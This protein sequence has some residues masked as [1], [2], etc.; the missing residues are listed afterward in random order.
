MPKGP[1]S[2]FTTTSSLT[3]SPLEPKENGEGAVTRFGNFEVLTN[4]DGGL[5]L[6]GGGGFG[7]T[8][9]AR[10]VYLDQIVALKVIN[11]R[12]LHDA[13]IKE[14][15]LREAQVVHQL[16][17]P[18]IAH[19]IDFGEVKHSL[20]YAMEFCG[21][22]NLENMVS[23]VGPLSLPVALRC[24][25]QLTEALGCAH[26]RGFIHRDVK[27]ANV[28]LMAADDEN[29]QIKL[30]DF[31]LVKHLQGGGSE[32][33]AALTATGQ[34][35]FTIQFASPEQL[36]EE[37]LDPRS[38]LFALGMTIWFLLKGS[39]P[40][41]GSMASI[42][43]RRL[44][45]KSYEAQLPPDLPAAYRV[46]LARLLEKD[47]THRFQDTSEVLAALDAAEAAPD[48]VPGE[49]ET[50]AGG[51]T[52]VLPRDLEAGSAPAGPRSILEL[53]TVLENLGPMPL[54]TL[55]RATSNRDD[56]QVAITMVGDTLRED[57][58]QRA[59]IE[60]NVALLRTQPHETMAQIYGLEE[61]QEGLALIQE[62]HRGVSLQNVLKSARSLHYPDALRVLLPIARGTDWTTRQ[63]LPGVVLA[64]DEI[65]LQPLDAE[66]A[67]PDPAKLLDMP[68]K[69]WPPFRVRLLPYVIREDT[70]EDIGR[71]LN[72]EI[73]A[74][75]AVAFACLLYH[76]VAGHTPRAAAR[77]SKSAYVTI[78]RFTEDSNRLLA[79]CIAG[80]QDFGGCEGMLRALNANEGVSFSSGQS[81]PDTGASGAGLL[82]VAKSGVVEVRRNP[83]AGGGIK[84]GVLPI[85]RSPRDLAREAEEIRAKKEAEEALLRK[86]QAD[87]ERALQEAEEA[88][89]RKQQADEERAKKEAEEARL[90]KQQ[91]EE[92]RTRKEAA[93]KLLKQ[94]QAEEARLRQE[95]AEKLLK[96]R[97]A[98]EAQAKKL[99][100]EERARKEAA[101]QLLKQRQAEEAQAK[102]LAEEERA[103]KEAEAKQLKK[104]QAEEE[105]ARKE[106][107][108]RQL[109]QKQA[110]EARA[111]KQADEE[112]AKKEAEEARLRKQQAEEERT[113]KEAAEKLLKQRQAEEARLRQEAAEK[114]LK[115]KQA[116]EAQA[117][118]LAEEERARKEAAEKLLKQ[119]QAEEARA[120]KQAEE[121]RARKEAE[122]ARLRK[123]QAEEE[124][125]R[126][127]AAE[128]LLKQQQAEEARAK[129]LAAQTLK[130]AA[131]V[132]TSKPGPGI[133][134]DEGGE[135]ETSSGL[136]PSVSAAAIAASVALVGVVAFVVLHKPAPPKQ[137]VASPTPVA[138]DTPKPTPTAAP[139]AVPLP[140]QFVFKQGIV[141]TRAAITLNGQAVNPIVDGMKVVVPLDGAKA[142][143]SLEV[144]APGYESQSFPITGSASVDGRVELHRQQ[145]AITFQFVDG[146]SDYAAAVFN[147]IKALPGEEAFV[148]MDPQDTSLALAAGT[149]GF[150][151]TGIYRVTLIARPSEPQIQGRVLEPRLSV[152]TQRNVLTIPPSFAGRYPFEFVFKEDVLTPQ[153]LHKID[154]IKVRRTIVIDPGL[155][156]GYADD[157]YEKA[158]P[159]TGTKITDLT[160]NNQ[161]VLHGFIRF[162]KRTDTNVS[163]DEQFELSYVD[164]H[165]DV[166]SGGWEVQP[167]AAEMARLVQKQKNL[168]GYKP[169]LNPPPSQVVRKE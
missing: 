96:Q 85:G 108:A 112:R 8:Y 157:F 2:N 13:S 168:Q 25:R 67:G 31:G 90:R 35:F 121:E 123:Q 20:Y 161:G 73:V 69:S 9:K 99:A 139:T 76:L 93:E 140:G 155:Q 81:K 109:K 124:R 54:G 97:Q 122:E 78:G 156:T 110:E 45:G 116:E 98:E 101:E 114:L 129:K 163:C 128:K 89:L 127:A 74:D 135:R 169:H 1:V 65:Y 80:E 71:T 153:K 130:Q 150:L 159:A 15:F 148:H 132:E 138:V 4:P 61:Y 131:V 38:D 18:N 32:A 125:A 158:A 26:S 49:G 24:A 119:R 152:T 30:V 37:E 41:A 3:G 17:H 134:T 147:P 126:Q 82:A 7:K 62:W 92:E 63:G 83:Q 53:Y 105:R 33:T 5:H 58:L 117:K 70:I 16:R 19:V 107:E 141:P 160:L 111:K 151:P 118:K 149:K 55:Y 27:P 137:E 21:G 77:L 113:R 162:T 40:E 84:G 29:P 133:A 95:A 165:F 66:A 103:R 22:G 104:Q 102:K 11:D 136:P 39:A 88:L 57:P 166:V 50:G 60:K 47:R 100:E 144:K 59:V 154:E 145:G 23:R 6:L 167:S 51:E 48:A 91:A 14:R 115:Q 12:L 72:T 120:K 34:Q 36:M 43:A 94:K 146:T 44:D 28:M 68:L 87:E 42:V 75:P 143:D 56:E 10:H 46:L 64:M 86:Q 164:H 106:A 52:V 79:A 142:G